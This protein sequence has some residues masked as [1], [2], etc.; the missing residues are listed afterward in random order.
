MDLDSELN[1]DY[2]LDARDLGSYLK[3]LEDHSQL[4]GVLADPPYAKHFAATIESGPM[5]FQVPMQS[6]R[7]RWRS[8]R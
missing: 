2:C 8:C 5:C 1:S 7:V 6:S 3:I 4:R